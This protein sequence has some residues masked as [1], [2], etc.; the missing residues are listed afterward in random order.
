MRCTFFQ[1]GPSYQTPPTRM[2]RW[3]SL[4]TSATATPSAR[5]AVSTTV[6]FQVIAAAAE[7]ASTGPA[8]NSS[9]ARTGKTS[10]QHR[11]VIGA[12][13]EV[14]RGRQVAAAA[15]GLVRL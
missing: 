4:L 14:L 1:S 5:K 6:F 8:G 7:S 11:D 12:P 9:A 2:S 10:N 3:P 13:R 15:D